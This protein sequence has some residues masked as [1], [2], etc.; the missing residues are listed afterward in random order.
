M[1]KRQKKAS[2]ASLR[3]PTRDGIIEIKGES[4]QIVQGSLDEALKALERLEKLHKK[5]P[6]TY[7]GVP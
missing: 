5:R 1:V 2:G 7:T 4:M 3:I 6:G